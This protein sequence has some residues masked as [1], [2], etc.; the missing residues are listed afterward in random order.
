VTV[1]VIQ[2]RPS[3][4]TVAATPTRVVA[5]ARG[6]QGRGGPTV[7]IPFHRQGVALPLVG[8]ARWRFPFAATLTGVSAACA[9]APEGSGI[10]FAVL[11]NGISAGSFVLP[12]GSNEMDEVPVSVPISVG[13]YV[14]VNIISVG[15][16]ANGED[17]T[18]FVRY[19][20]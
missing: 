6:V 10:V 13:D 1:Y 12:D 5:S 3:T 11:V 15:S 17:L 4:V 19:V 2:T 20:V 8:K 9:V 7:P 16:S 18:I 14:T